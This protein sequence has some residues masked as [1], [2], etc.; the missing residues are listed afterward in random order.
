MPS[1]TAA[2]RPAARWIRLPG[3]WWEINFPVPLR[4][5]HGSL[6]NHLAKSPE[7]NQSNRNEYEHRRHENHTSV[8]RCQQSRSPHHFIIPTPSS[9]L[10]SDTWRA[11]PLVSWP[12]Y[13]GRTGPGSMPRHCSALRSRHD[14]IC[15]SAM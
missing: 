15:F 2:P 14:D 7:E 12:G 10:L 5:V 8:P 6:H 3:G 1:S 9:E 11:L 4:Q 13:F